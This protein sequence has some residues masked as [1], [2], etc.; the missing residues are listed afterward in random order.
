MQGSIRQPRQERSRRR[1]A[2]LLDAA[3]EE[4]AEL[5]F[6]AATTTGVAARA[7][8]P[9]GSLYQWFSDKDALLFGLADRHLTEA[10]ST[11][12]DAL[13]RARAA[14]DLESSVRILVEAAVEA[15]GG[16]PRVHRI[17]YREAPRPPELQA[18]LVELEDALVAWVSDELTRRGVALGPASTLRARTLVVAVEALVHDVVLDPPIGASRPEVISEVVAA[19][20][21]IAER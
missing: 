8:V 10:A 6:S 12:L 20:V 19:A 3:A 1:V 18:R 16:D 9:I 14:A 21:A 2:A 11:L 7:G 13:D 5:G 15:N 17:L 4:F